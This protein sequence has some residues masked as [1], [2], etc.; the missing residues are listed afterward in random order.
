MKVF[1]NPDTY[2]Y[3]NTVIT[4]GMF[5]G[6]H[7]GHQ[8][9]LKAV[10]HKAHELNAKAVVLTFWP[11]PR[12]VLSKNTDDLKLITSLDE[13]TKLIS[14]LGIDHIIILPFNKDMASLTAEEFI[15]QILKNKFGISHLVMGFN[16]KF[17]SDRISDFN[18]YKQIAEKY[19]IGISRVEAIH[20][21]HEMVSSTNTRNA[22]E[23]GDVKK[24]SAFL[25][26]PFSINGV[27]KGGQKLGRTIGYPTANLELT[28]K[29][30]IVPK[31]GVYACWVTIVG[32]KYGG[33]LNIGYRPTINQ[34]DPLPSIEIHIFDFNQDIYSEEI[35]IH[36]VDRI[37][38][39]EK[40]KNIEALKDQLKKDEQ[41]I[42]GI[43]KN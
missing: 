19:N 22:L 28:E 18:I 42:R 8:Q 15:S 37:R 39:E 1:T 17:G 40:F 32:K 24:A 4:I 43:L 16:H 6:V 12:L 14:E 9:L 30:K 2:N 27:V 34:K 25:G 35:E 41:Q 38:N 36:F 3:A 11:H 13:K 31:V 21:N 23:N 10:V 29:L 7:K 26:M 20:I 5:D 33:M